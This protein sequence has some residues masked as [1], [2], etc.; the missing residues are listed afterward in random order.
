MLMRHFHFLLRLR[1]IIGFALVISAACLTWAV[2]FSRD[3]WIALDAQEWNSW[4]PTGWTDDSVPGKVIAY[5]DVHYRIDEQYLY[6]QRNGRVTLRTRYNTDVPTGPVH[7]AIENGWVSRTIFLLNRGVFK[8]SAWEQW[9]LERLDEY[10][11]EE[12][13][14]EFICPSQEIRRIKTRFESHDGMYAIVPSLHTYAAAGWS[15][16]LDDWPS[17]VD[18]GDLVPLLNPLAPIWPRLCEE[19]HF[20]WEL[21][22]QQ[23]LSLNQGHHRIWI[24]FPDEIRDPTFTDAAWDYAAMDICAERVPDG[25]TTCRLLKSGDS[26]ARHALL[27]MPGRYRFFQ[28]L[29]G[30]LQQQSC[31]NVLRGFG[32][33]GPCND[34]KLWYWRKAS[35]PHAPVEVQLQDLGPGTSVGPQIGVFS[36]DF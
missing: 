35:P 21:Y 11:W 19:P 12:V 1:S 26:P 17:K 4:Y 31:G 8:V 30:E 13:S 27:L 15:S 29:H 25:Q 22:E 28:R 3:N 2:A 18:T 33:S 34:G 6:G 5:T 16:R 36:V 9:G 10:L 7:Y 14:Y 20:S 24:P 23:K 32:N